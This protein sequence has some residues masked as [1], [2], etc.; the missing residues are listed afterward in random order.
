[1]KWA[2]AGKVLAVS[3][4]GIVLAIVLARIGFLI[5]ERQGYQSEAAQSVAESLAGAQTLVGPVLRRDCA[6]TWTT[7]RSDSSRDAAVGDDRREFALQALPA[8]LKVDGDSRTDLRYRGIFKVNG[9]QARLRLAAHWDDLAA[10][11]AKPQHE[12]GRVECGPLRLWFATAD[13]RGLRSAELTVDGQPLPV[14]PGLGHPSPLNGLHAE[15]GARTAGAVDAL[16]QVDLVGTAQLALVPVADRNEWAL[17]SDWPHPSFGGRFLP[18]DRVVHDNGFE[19]QW[20]VSALATSAGRAVRSGLPLCRTDR[21]TYAAPA[22]AGECLDTLAVDFVDPVNPYTLADRAVK[23]GLLY[24]LLTFVAVGLVEALARDRVR[25]VHPVQYGLVGLTMCLFFLLLLSLSEHLAF[26]TAYGIA[27]A[28]CVPLL[29]VYARHMLGRTVDGLWFGAGV[30]AL[31]G[32]MYLLLQ[33]EQTA[34]LIGSLGLFAV[35]A[36]VMLA[37]RRT[38]WYALAAR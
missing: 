14:R 32:L 8:R 3:G 33:R 28:A 27:T 23:Y 9:Y 5:D 11:D 18:A 26:G 21:R 1:M 4:T 31:Y 15:I 36:A 30:G 7:A 20:R 24:V 35:V 29:A 34:L 38:D 2:W 10:L 13:V 17:R 6:E 12:G 37:T 19:A 25:R 22:A 16:L